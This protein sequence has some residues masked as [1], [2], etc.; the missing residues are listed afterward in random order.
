MKREAHTKSVTVYLYNAIEDEW[1][2]LQATSDKKTQKIE[3]N[4]CYEGAECFLYFNTE[5]NDL[6]YVTGK[7]ISKEYIEYYQTFVGKKNVEIIVPLPKTGQISLDLLED[8]KTFNQFIAR[9]K[10][11]DLITIKVYSASPQFYQLLDRLSELNLPLSAPEAPLPKNAWTVNFFGSKVGFRQL[12]QKYSGAGNL[13]PM[14]RGYI[15]PSRDDAARIAAKIFTEKRG[16]V[17]KTSK[18]NEGNGVLIFFENDL[19]YSYAAC[20]KKISEILRMNAYWE[21]FPIVVE[22]LIDVDKN[23]GGGF[24]S[25]EG[26]VTSGG[27]P[28]FLYYCV[29]RVTKKGA[30]YGV[31]IHNSLLDTHIGKQVT[32]ITLKVAKEYAQEGYRGHFDVDFLVDKKGKIFA[33]ESNT[34]NNGSSDVAKLAVKF[35]GPNFPDKTYLISSFRNI[36]F[37]GSRTSVRFAEIVSFSTPILFSHTTKEGVMYNGAF[38]LNNKELFYTV[39]APNKQAAYRYEKRMAEIFLG[40]DMILTDPE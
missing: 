6:M 26:R 27:K 7:P 38:I 15:C 28:E 11:Y 14:P 21:K 8:K 30:F 18:G 35:F 32:D 23:I 36:T 19:P 2:F 29:M 40:H 4:D 33:N 31:E 17:I 10:S 13:F 25:A 37:T 1:P 24:P 5:Q 12:S 3:I 22:E 34:R 20:T 39:F 9:L 16:V